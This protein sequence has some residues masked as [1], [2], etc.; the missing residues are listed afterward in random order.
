VRLKLTGVFAILLALGACAARTGDLP[1]D[2]VRVAPGVT[3][4]LPSPREL[5]RS[6]EAVQLISA[7]YGDQTFVFESHVSATPERFLLVGLDTLGRKVMTITWTDAG[8]A[9]ETASWVP[10]QLR[11]ANVLADIVLLYWPEE[12]VRRA[13]RGGL[14]KV[15]HDRRDVIADGHDVIWAEFQ[16]SIAG[17]P[18]S[19]HLHYE[20]V[21]WGYALDVQ[22]MEA[23]K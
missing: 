17:D 9:H 6:F 14:L 7:R 12:S 11:P 4:E 1:P 20:N 22:S 8:I 3:L 16:P 18:W 13:L 23:P 2:R 5:A 19:G 15:G 10:E 21:A